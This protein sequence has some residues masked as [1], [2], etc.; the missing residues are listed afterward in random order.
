VTPRSAY[1]LSAPSSIWKIRRVAASGEG[2][3]LVVVPLVT[4]PGRLEGDEWVL[5][6]VKLQG[7]FG[8]L[9]TSLG[10]PPEDGKFDRFGGL[11]GGLCRVVAA[12]GEE[13]G[14]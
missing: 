8:R 10:T 14:G 9:G 5:V 2:G 1:S 7:R 12:G 13:R 11:R 6:C 3:E 4:L